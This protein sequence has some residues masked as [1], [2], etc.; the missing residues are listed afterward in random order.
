M[1][2]KLQL[3]ALLSA[4]VLMPAQAAA[5]S[6]VTLEI[7]G[8]IDV[9]AYDINDVGQ[10]V[11]RFADNAG[12][13]GFLWDGRSG[14]TVL[15]VPG[16]TTTFALGMNEFGQVVG[17]ATFSFAGYT[18]PFV[19]DAVSGFATISLPNAAAASA[20]GVNNSGDV[21]GQ[22]FDGKSHGFLRDAA[23]TVTLFDVPGATRT[24]AAGINDAGQ[25]V[26]SFGNG[27][28]S[29]GFLRTIAG[30][31]IT[32]D[33][34]ES[35]WTEA[36]FD[37]SVSGEIVG[38]FYDKAQETRQ[39]GFVRSSDGV[40][41]VLDVPGSTGTQSFGINAAGQIVGAYQDT[42][43]LPRLFVATPISL[44]PIPPTLGLL[45]FALAGLGLALRRSA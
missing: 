37:I 16:A 23:G 43:A 35:Q 21:V 10:V 32:L 25:I 38:H 15:D 8:A 24:L 5:Y 40:Y 34:P 39:H 28:S 11:G 44:V 1:I 27:G 42:G 20:F 31:F 22:I 2:K 19:W 41:S 12:A 29:H 17:A 18:R 45:A 26:G 4:W 33:P 14:L 36:A 7:P 13:H 9:A 6:F 3:M 30:E